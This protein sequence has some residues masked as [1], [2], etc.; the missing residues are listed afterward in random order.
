MCQD[1]VTLLAFLLRREPLAHLPITPIIYVH[2][3]GLIQILLLF[4]RHNDDL[5]CA[6]R[7]G[8]RQRDRIFRTPSASPS[9]PERTA[10]AAQIIVGLLTCTFGRYL[11]LR[12]LLS[13]LRFP[14]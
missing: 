14:Q 10:T 5:H 12:I 13:L 3:A 4:C 11:R 2:I 8:Q 7:L 6:N 1:E 9:P